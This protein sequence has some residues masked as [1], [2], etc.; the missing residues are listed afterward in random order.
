MITY[1][2]ECPKCEMHKEV[3]RSIND[4]SI[5]CCDSCKDVQMHIVIGVS[6]FHLKGTG[7]FKT[8]Y[9]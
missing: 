9:K 5:V 6:G 7:W 4:T 3:K 2:Y 1:E 8:D